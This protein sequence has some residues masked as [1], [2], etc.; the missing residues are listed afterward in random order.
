[1]LCKEF[2]D[3]IMILRFF[4]IIPKEAA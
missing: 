2:P 3:R 1:M 4:N